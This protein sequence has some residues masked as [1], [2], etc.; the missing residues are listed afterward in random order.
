V[1]TGSLLRWR[2]PGAGM[3]LTTTDSSGGAVK[4]IIYFAGQQVAQRVVSGSAVSYYFGDQ[5]G[6]VRLAVNAT[7]TTCWDADYYPFGGSNVFTSTCQPQYRYALTET[8][9]TMSNDVDYATFRYYSHRFAR[10]ISPDPIGGAPTNPQTW[11]RYAYVS[12]NP[13]SFVDPLGLNPL[14]YVPAVDPSTL[15]QWFSQL[16]GTSQSSQVQTGTS[17]ILFD[18]GSVEIPM[19]DTITT[20]PF[21]SLGGFG[22]FDFLRPSMDLGDN[23]GMK[24]A[25]NKPTQTPQQKRSSPAC[26]QAKAT[27]STIN[28]QIVALDQ[29][30]RH[31]LFRDMKN[32]AIVGCGIGVIGGEAL[33]T[34]A[35]GTPA[36]VGNCAVGAI[37][38]ALTENAVY[39]LGHLDE[40]GSAFSLMGSQAKAIANVVSACY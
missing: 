15:Q 39:T 34:P 40:V 16:A 35:I 5:V 17:V 21:A 37:G 26:Q 11:N 19:F 23:G 22:S 13:L 12:N 2:M 1:K 10:F 33:E 9:P 6:S 27:L 38:G 14:P 25:R 32:G 30:M 29:S 4:D 31:D 36:A 8:E 28:Q 18:I 24:D 7:A 20:Y 3:Y